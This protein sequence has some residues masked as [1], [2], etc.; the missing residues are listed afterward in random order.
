[1]AFKNL[2]RYKKRTLLTFLLIS[3]AVAIFIWM[4]GLARGIREKSFENLI[5]FTTSHFQIRTTGYDEK[6]PFKRENFINNYGEL[7]KI[8]KNN[9]EIKSYTERIRF[10]GEIDNGV[11]SAPVIVWGINLKK[12]RSVFNLQE[13]IKS[14]HLSKDGAIIGENLAIDMKLKVGDYIYLTTKTL[15]GFYDSIEL[16]ITG[17]VNAADPQINNSAIFISL[18]KAQVFINTNGVTEIA[19]RVKHFKLLL[20][21]IRSIRK[22]ISN[23]SIIPWNILGKNYIAFAKADWGSG[24]VFIYLLMIVAFVGILNTM[25]MSVLEKRKEIGTLKALGMLDGEIEKIFIYEGLL[26]GVFGFI[27]GAIMGGLLNIYLVKNGIDFT[28]LVGSDDAEFG[29]KVMGLIHARWS[30]HQFLDPLIMSLITTFLASY[31]PAKRTL[32]LK[33]A[34]AIRK[35]Q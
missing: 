27:F 4:D 2:I 6:K 21:T 3:F 17:I 13:F 19:F 30:I 34:E 24:K 1:M 26:I 20:F 33:P 22:K 5:N 15:K 31:F 9:E 25:L 35:S 32:K 7:E 16:P 12:D 29:Y 14:G 23:Y 11:D 28:K 18:K 10:I 8:L